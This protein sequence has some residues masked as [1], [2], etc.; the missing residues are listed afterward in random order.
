M[1]DR[2]LQ[3]FY[4]VAKQLSFTK[5]AECLCMTQPA[6][7]FQV[8]QLE[9]QLNISL[10]ERTPSKII[11]TPAGE[12]AMQYAEKILGMT[13]E[14]ETRLAEMGDQ[15]NGALM[16]GASTTIA[17][18]MLPQMLGVFKSRFPQVQLRLFVANSQT[19]ENRIIDHSLDVGLVESP[20]HHPSLI[21]QVFYRDELVVICAIDHEWAQFDSIHPEQLGNEPYIGREPGSG[22]REVVDQYLRE[23]RVQPELLE[24][25]MELG[26]PEAI[27]G[28]V[29]AGLGVAIVSKA[30][31][32][33]E[34]ELGKLAAI[35]LHP[36]LRRDLTQVYTQEKFRTRLLQ[37]FIDLIT[38]TPQS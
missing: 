19:I 8:K 18:Y 6:V 26:S 7:T 24:V 38:E 16:I 14:M 23:H 32:E 25:V 28:A 11:L 29:E 17:D 13:A 5:A 35:P 9:A 21:T 33:K 36:P 27:K 20:S 37:S 4:T 3:V 12:L 2:R 30:T 34:R 10:F 31:V 1:A 22:T 15:I